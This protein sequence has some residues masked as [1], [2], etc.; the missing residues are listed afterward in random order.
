MLCHMTVEH[1]LPDRRQ[2]LVIVRQ[3]KV[4]VLVEVDGVVVDEGTYLR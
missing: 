1:Q 2:F 3:S 4:P